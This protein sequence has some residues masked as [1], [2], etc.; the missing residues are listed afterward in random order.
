[1]YTGE[2]LSEKPMPHN[3]DP[4]PAPAAACYILLHLSGHMPFLKFCDN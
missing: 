1:M 2:Q 3:T 4:D